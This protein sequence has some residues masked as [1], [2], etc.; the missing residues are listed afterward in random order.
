MNS[1]PFHNTKLPP[2]SLMHG[3]R[4]ANGAT[5]QARQ[6]DLHIVIPHPLLTVS[7]L[8]EEWSYNERHILDLIDAGIVFAFFI[9]AENLPQHRHYRIPREAAVKGTQLTLAGMEHL[10]ATVEDWLLPI[11]RFGRRM[12]LAVRDCGAALKISPRHVRSLYDAGQFGGQNLGAGRKEIS[13]RI[14]RPELVAFVQHRL[15][16]TNLSSLSSVSSVVKK[17]GQKL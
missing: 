4:S 3:A 13:L 17:S 8:A 9:N 7:D 16:F 5:G 1:A 12:N 11:E 14:P 10:I 15:R 6:M 2:A